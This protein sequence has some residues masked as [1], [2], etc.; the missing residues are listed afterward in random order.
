MVSLAT[1]LRRNSRIL[2]KTNDRNEFFSAGVDRY[3]A[4]TPLFPAFYSF[5]LFL[6]TSSFHE[7]KV[8]RL[9]FLL[10]R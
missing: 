4:A 10:E 9:L 3:F 1:L 8:G 2:R 7:K 6:P 5:L